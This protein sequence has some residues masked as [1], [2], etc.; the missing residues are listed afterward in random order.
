VAQSNKLELIPSQRKQQPYLDF[1]IDGRRLTQLL[2]TK[3][4]GGIDLIPSFG[5]PGE[6]GRQMEREAAA[7]LLRMAEPDL[8]KERCSLLVC[9]E[10]ADLGCGVVTAVVERESD[11]YVWREFGFE[12][13]CN[14]ELDLAS[15]EHIYQ[16]TFNRDEYSGIF[17]P[18]LNG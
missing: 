2:F 15:F 18:Y 11:R 12:M 16:L 17:R 5:W 6:A 14:P 7:R 9:P 10:C 13:P 3:G 4:Y 1:L 8:P